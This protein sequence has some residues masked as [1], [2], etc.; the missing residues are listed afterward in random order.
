MFIVL[1]QGINQP[2]LWDSIQSDFQRLRFTCQHRDTPFMCI[3]FSK[4][5]NNGPGYNSIKE[6]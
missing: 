1:Y 5:E 3:R 6:I 2:S 4:N